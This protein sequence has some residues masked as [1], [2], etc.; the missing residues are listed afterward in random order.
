MKSK[1]LILGILAFP[2]LAVL[3]SCDKK[4]QRNQELEIKE[5]TTSPQFKSS[6]ELILSHEITCVGTCNGIA[7]TMKINPSTL[8]LSCSCSDCS[9]KITTITD[10][11]KGKKVSLRNDISKEIS[12]FNKYVSKTFGEKSII[13]ITKYRRDAFQ[14]VELLY[15]TYVLNDNFSTEYT[16]TAITK[17]KDGGNKDNNEKT[18]TIVDCVGSCSD[19]SQQCAEVYNIN[20]GLVSCGCEGDKCQMRIIV[21]PQE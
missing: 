2:I 9:I 18:I 8:I 10:N 5:V 1:V 15:F 17:F 11:T 21:N 19:A 7:C 4:E 16:A 14:D 13:G 12:L 6:S 20:T 3:H